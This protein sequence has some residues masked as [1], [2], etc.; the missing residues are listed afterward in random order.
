MIGRLLEILFTVGVLV[1]VA[2]AVLNSGN[3]KSILEKDDAPNIV[4]NISVS[5]GANVVDDNQIVEIEVFGDE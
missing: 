5:E 2:M 1:I 3:Y 4:E